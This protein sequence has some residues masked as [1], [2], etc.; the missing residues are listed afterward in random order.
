MQQKQL[1]V[2]IAAASIAA[3][4]LVGAIAGFGA[5][6]AEQPEQ[7]VGDQTIH[8]SATGE[9]TA[10]P[11]E[12]IVGVAVT[13]EGE[14]PDEVR[15]QL[16]TGAADLTER[17]DE[18]D[19][20]YETTSYDVRQPRRPPEERDVPD[21]VGAH[22]FEVTVEDP[23]DVGTVIDAAAD[24]G[25]EID[26]VELTLSDSQREQLRSVAIEDA[27]ADA[28]AQAETIANT[29]GL[30]V[31]NVQTVDASQRSFSPVRTE[32][33]MAD[34]AEDDSAPPTVIASGDVSI[35]YDVSVTYNATVAASE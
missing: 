24:A 25:A 23:D 27:M 17:L 11:D 30:A 31:T 5:A 7:S 8:V 33:A 34:V 21:Y 20:D 4:V 12:G 13:A 14:A 19:V 3:V 6:G 29:S 22:A 16:A 1:A 9:A 28:D 15:D 2:L 10:E 35:S 26:G 18:L 32:L